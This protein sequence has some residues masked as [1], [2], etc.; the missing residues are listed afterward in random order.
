[1]DAAA[2]C[3][4]AVVKVESV[5]SFEQVVQ[6]ETDSVRG[7]CMRWKLATRSSSPTTVVFQQILACTKTTGVVDWGTPE[8][9]PRGSTAD[10]RRGF[11]VRSL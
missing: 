5:A 11:V 6:H 9:F 3:M 4:G 1:M 7:G 2:Q 10:I 8:C